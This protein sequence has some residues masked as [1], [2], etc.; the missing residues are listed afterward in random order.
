MHLVVAVLALLLAGSVSAASLK[1]TNES[2]RRETRIIV[3]EGLYF[4]ESDLEL[5]WMKREGLLVPIPTVVGLRIDRRLDERYR[6][7]L[8]RVADFLSC[9]A[10]RFYREKGKPLQ[11]NSAVRTAP[12]Q[13][14]LVKD[15]GNAAA[16]RG[17]S[18]STHL[19]GAAIDIAKLG[20]SEQELL[21]LREWL[22][23][24]EDR[25]YVEAT[26]EYRQAVFHVVVMRPLEEE[27]C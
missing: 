25:G 26:E 15:N 3:E 18:R 5:E 23:W 13:A 1:G 9:F 6:F 21:W 16:A 4:I 14:I 19:T 12:F 24:L 8:P 22:L 20:R 10:S 7:V 17:E 27:D 11:I 2:Q